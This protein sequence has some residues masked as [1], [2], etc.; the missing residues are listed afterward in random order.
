MTDSLY[1]SH[2]ETIGRRWSA[3]LA[4]TDFD[5]VVITAGDEV[6]Y[7][8]DDQSPPF[9]V[10][11]HFAQW[12]PHNDCAGSLLVYRPG[13]PPTLH[14]YQPADFWHAPPSPPEW[15]DGA[16][17]VELHATA[18]AALAGALRD[19]P[20]SERFALVGPQAIGN[21]VPEQ[22]NPATLIA[23]MNYG[24][25]IKT[26]FETAGMRVAT[27]TAVAGHLAARD[28]FYQQASEFDILNA[29]LAA[30]KQVATQTPYNSIVALNEHAAVLHYQHYDRQ[31]PAQAR[32]FLIDAGARHKCYASDI[33]RTYAQDPGSDFGALIQR[34]DVEQQALCLQLE[35]GVEYPVFHEAMHRALAGVLVDHNLLLCSAEAAFEARLTETFLPHGL[36]HLLGLQTHDVGGQQATPDGAPKPPPA[37]YPALRFTREVAVG[38]VFTIEPGIY[39]IPMLLDALRTG[40]HAANV[41]WP[42]VDALVPFG[43]IRIEDNVLITSTGVDNLTRNSF[44]SAGVTQVPVAGPVADRDANTTGPAHD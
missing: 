16:L 3:A 35:P 15:L 33:T 1:H 42:Q 22:H 17:E 9:R 40:E 6:P 14:F 12:F 11:P 4:A 29:F 34:L 7:F 41:N 24:R 43:G 44:V 32:S 38:Q 23:H 20:G 31:P 21:V 27:D 25:A 13:E 30:S 37:R 26:D 28:A 36:G 10:N 8:M 19:I 39:F 2:I 18:E 5:A